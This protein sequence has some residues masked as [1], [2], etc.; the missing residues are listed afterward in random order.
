MERVKSIKQYIFVIRQLN[1]REIRKQNSE[2][3][4]GAFWNIVNPLL[5]MIIM[6]ALY[7]TIFRHDIENFQVYFFSGYIVYFLYKTGM[8][9]AMLSIVQNKTF[10]LHTKIPMKIFIFERVY[11]ALINSMYMIIAFVALIF[12]YHIPIGLF[13]IL[14]IP[15]IV[16]IVLTVFGF[17][18][19]LA[20]VYVYFEDMRHLYSIFMT[21]V[22]FAS[23]IIFPIERV[24]EMLQLVI[25]LTPVYNSIYLFRGVIMYG[26]F[27]APIDWLKQII[28]CVFALTIGEIV[29]RRNMNKLVQKI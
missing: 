21:L 15:I 25:G 7:G 22:M 5:F 6:S 29:F 16:L 18:E 23:A 13:D 4:L 14:V 19:I 27:P 20:V 17:G 24:S 3:Y 11:T 28:W 9:G 8:E 12:Y 1:R 10:L 2:T 26:I